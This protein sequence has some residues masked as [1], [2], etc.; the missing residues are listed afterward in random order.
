MQV[1]WEYSS[2]EKPGAPP[3]L[4]CHAWRLLILTNLLLSTQAYPRSRRGV[5][6]EPSVEFRLSRL[7]SPVVELGAVPVLSGIV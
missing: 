2:A 5:R 6:M 4:T 7:V 1:P 3:S